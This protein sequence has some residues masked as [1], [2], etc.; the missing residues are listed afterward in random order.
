LKTPKLEGKKYAPGK[1]LVKLICAYCENFQIVA[2]RR[3]GL[4]IFI[5]E[6]SCLTH[7]KRDEDEIITVCHGNCLVRED[8]L[9]RYLDAEVLD[10]NKR[11]KTSAAAD[12]CARQNLKVTARSLEKAILIPSELHIAEDVL[13]NDEG[14]SSARIPSRGESRRKKRKQCYWCGKM[15]IGMKRHMPNSAIC[16]EYR[17]YNKWTPPNESNLTISIRIPA[18]GTEQKDDDDKDTDA[19]EYESESD[20]ENEE[21][22]IN[23][24]ELNNAP[25]IIQG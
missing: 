21:T 16:A 9:K 2:R 15:M 13:G 8:H 1:D 23:E 17:R 12:F 11:S 3:K 10:G 24:D 6:Q 22:Y 20:S 25:E 7:G 18:A 4:F 5:E 14:V 19:Q